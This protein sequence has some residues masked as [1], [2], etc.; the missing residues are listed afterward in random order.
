LLPA[1]LPLLS[2]EDGERMIG[3]SRGLVLLVR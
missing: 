2:T 1:A 3:E